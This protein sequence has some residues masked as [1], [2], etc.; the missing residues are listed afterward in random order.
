MSDPL[1]TMF[2]PK[3][4]R[5]CG[6]DHYPGGCAKSAEARATAWETR[7]AKYGA[8]GHAGY[9]PRKGG[10]QLERDALRLIVTLHN[11]GTLSEGQCCQALD[12]DR[13][14]FR[15]LC[16]DIGRRGDS[17]GERIFLARKKAR[18]TQEQLSERVGVSRAQIANIEGGRSDVPVRTLQRIAQALGINAGA[19]I[20]DQSACEASDA[21]L[22]NDHRLEAINPDPPTPGR[23]LK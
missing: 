13:V 4:C 15:R 8:A 16:D 2:G 21:A 7:R 6:A 17:V 20:P 23:T 18:L 3:R 1:T 9:G 19:L 5:H 12:L 22:P 11:E 14:D 10:S